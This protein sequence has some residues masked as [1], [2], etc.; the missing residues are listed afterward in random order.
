MRYSMIG[1]LLAA[2]ALLTVATVS[3]YAQNTGACYTLVNLW[4]EHP[5]PIQ[6]TNYHKG[7]LIPV[8]SK[9]TILVSTPGKI[10]FTYNGQT[11]TLSRTKYTRVDMNTVQARTFGSSNP[12]TGKP[13][14]DLPKTQ[15]D[16]VKAGQ[17]ILGMPKPAV[18]MA[19]GY[20]PEHKTPTTEANYWMYWESKFLTQGVTFTDGKVSELKGF[21]P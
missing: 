21:R 13:F 4:V 8:G 16:A 6:T 18:L 10:E 14:T 7:E 9:V 11:L 19:Y 17:V 3:T 15:Q 12:L 20:P 5:K 2:A 1:S